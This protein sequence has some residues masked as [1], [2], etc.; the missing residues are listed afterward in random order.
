[1]QRWYQAI[2]IAHDSRFA[3]NNWSLLDPAFRQR[4]VPTIDQSLKGCK[5][6]TRTAKGLV[7]EPV[8]AKG[9]SEK[10]LL[11]AD[12]TGPPEGCQN[13]SKELQQADQPNTV[14]DT[15]LYCLAASC[16]TR[17][18]SKTTEFY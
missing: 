15:A 10:G 16:V 7:V 14:A 5:L 8:L 18:C 1:M 2:C 17:E 12:I 4:V 9:L 6:E 13:G 11:L 3:G